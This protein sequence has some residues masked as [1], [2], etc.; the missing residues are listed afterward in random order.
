LDLLK[1]S[2]EEFDVPRYAVTKTLSTIS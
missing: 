1:V 2:S